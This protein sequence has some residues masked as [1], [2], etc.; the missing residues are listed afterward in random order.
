MLPRRKKTPKGGPRPALVPTELPVFDA[1][2]DAGLVVV[3]SAD[4]RKQKPRPER[5]APGRRRK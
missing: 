4:D 3:M 5:P 1:L 2:Q